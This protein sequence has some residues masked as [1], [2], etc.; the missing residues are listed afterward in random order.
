MKSR[1]GPPHCVHSDGVA[2]R[3]PGAVH[4]AM[5]MAI[6]TMASLRIIAPA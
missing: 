6:A 1:V 2:A 3:P 4:S 5:E